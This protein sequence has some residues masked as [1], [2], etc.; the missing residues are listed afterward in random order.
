MLAIKFE[1]QPVRTTMFRAYGFVLAARDEHHSSVVSVE[2][3]LHYLVHL[4]KR[5]F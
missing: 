3:P 2:S 1:T 5:M 4:F